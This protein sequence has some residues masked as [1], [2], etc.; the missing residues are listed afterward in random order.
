MKS[1]LDSEKDTDPLFEVIKLS[2]PVH[3]SV[4]TTGYPVSNRVLVDIRV[5]DTDQK[6]KSHFGRGIRTEPRSLFGSSTEGAA[7]H[8]NLIS[9]NERSLQS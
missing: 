7:E 1:H 8:E 4:P 5:S 3:V 6:D 2:T 9:V